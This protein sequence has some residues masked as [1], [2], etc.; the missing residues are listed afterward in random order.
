[1]SQLSHAQF[2]LRR[3][4]DLLV[5][6]RPS[7][8][9]AVA[10]PRGANAESLDRL[11]RSASLVRNGW[12]TSNR[13]PRPDCLGIRTTRQNRPYGSMRGGWKRIPCRR[14]VE[15]LRDRA[16]VSRLNNGRA[17]SGE[18]ALR[19]APC[20]RRRCGG[21]NSASDHILFPAE[22]VMIMGAT[23]AGKR[24]NRSGSTAATRTPTALGIVSWR[25]WYVA[26]VNRRQILY[27]DPQLHS[28]GAKGR[29]ARPSLNALSR[30]SRRSAETW[31][32]CSPESSPLSPL[33]E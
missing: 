1:M 17:R 33:V 29:I 15:D 28:R 21:S 18:G 16:S 22:E 14:D 6:H 3:H 2:P 9:A 26:H 11:R 5:D 31:P 30:S 19:L 20:W 23:M 10:E 13:N 7:R 24:Q 32:V 12:P 27:V 4:P 8:S 25:R